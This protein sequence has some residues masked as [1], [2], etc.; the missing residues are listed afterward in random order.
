M[1]IV[2][3]SNIMYPKKKRC[4]NIGATLEQ[5]Y[6]WSTSRGVR[7]YL[8]L[9]SL[10]DHWSSIK[11]LT[12]NYLTPPC[13]FGLPSPIFC[14]FIVDSVLKFQC[15]VWSVQMLYFLLL[16][17]I[18]VHFSCKEF[19]SWYRLRCTVLRH[20]EH[21]IPWCLFS[22]RTNEHLDPLCSFN[23]ACFCCL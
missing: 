10:M 7:M 14:F 6:R 19:G 22:M 1:W 3:Y 12:Q 4:S 23:F 17:K 16:R 11:I 21:S 20:C 18:E 15:V 8:S 2:Q 5:G 9:Q 13:Q